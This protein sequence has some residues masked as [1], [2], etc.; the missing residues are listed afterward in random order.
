MNPEKLY[1]AD[2]SLD[3]GGILMKNL[4]KKMFKENPGGVR[5]D[6][7]VGLIDPWVYKAGKKP[8]IEQ[9]AGRLFSSPEH[10]ELSKFAIATMDDLD[11][12]LEADKEK[13]LKLFQKNKSENTA[14]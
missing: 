4:F 1:K 14:D 7:I 8:K 6:H 5:I 9:G 10:P 13:E 12:T 2:G 3:E 11:M